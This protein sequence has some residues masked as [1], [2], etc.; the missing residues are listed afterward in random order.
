MVPC[1]AYEVTGSSQASEPTID[2]GATE[3]GGHAAVMDMWYGAERWYSNGHVTC[4]SQIEASQHGLC[5]SLY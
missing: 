3:F 5:H 2:S 4:K 1:P